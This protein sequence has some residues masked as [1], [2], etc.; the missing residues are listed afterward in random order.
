MTETEDT[1]DNDDIENQK[2]NGRILREP[3][4]IKIKGQIFDGI[5]LLFV[6]CKDKVSILSF[7]RQGRKLETSNQKIEIQCEGIDNFGSRFIL[8]DKKRCCI[9]NVTNPLD[10]K[11]LGVIINTGNIWF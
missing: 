6:C 11:G 7:D 1:N 4:S 9:T 2:N 8:H 5:L 10:V 3:P